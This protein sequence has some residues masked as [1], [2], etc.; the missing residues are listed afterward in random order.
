MEASKDFVADSHSKTP[1][2]SYP[3]IAHSMIKEDVPAASKLQSSMEEIPADDVN[4][5]AFP[6][7][8]SEELYHQ[9]SVFFHDKFR[10]SNS[11]EPEKYHWKHAG[12]TTCTETCLGMTK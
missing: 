11:I 2:H 10:H 1:V 12:F 3:K 8:N 5:L 4:A 9:N 7:P 6:S